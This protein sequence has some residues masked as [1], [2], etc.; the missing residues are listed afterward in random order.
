VTSRNRQGALYT[1]ACT[2]QLDH[3]TYSP[4]N[5]IPAEVSFVVLKC[6]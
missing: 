5:C 3:S 4:L 2:L 1:I 6:A